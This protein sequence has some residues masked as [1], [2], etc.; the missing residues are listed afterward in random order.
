MQGGDRI[1]KQ[2]WGDIFAKQLHIGP[3]VLDT[4][5]WVDYMRRI[6]R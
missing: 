3:Y 5:G 6:G 2:F 4:P 1:A